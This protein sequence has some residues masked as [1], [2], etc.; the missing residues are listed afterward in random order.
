MTVR[1]VTVERMT[2]TDPADTVDRRERLL[3]QIVDYVLENGIAQLT[4]RGL[5]TAVGSNNRMLLYYFGS[6][7]EL[8]V[9]ALHGAESR[10]PGM[11]SLFAGL[12]DPTVPLGDRLE[13]VWGVVAD[14]ANLPFHRLFFEIFGLA[15]FERERFSALLGLIGS[16]WVDAVAAAFRVSGVEAERSLLLAHETVAMW[17]GFQATLLTGGDAGVVG[18]V[19]DDALRSI[20]ERARVG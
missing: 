13:R 20:V 10:F 14:P 3:E 8:V 9:E 4:L 18:R 16:E 7:E 19:A 6:R 5:A 17:R 1:P 15:G 12:D 11:A 2:R